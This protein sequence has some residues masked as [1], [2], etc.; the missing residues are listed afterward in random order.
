MNEAVGLLIEAA[1][2]NAGADEP[3]KTGAPLPANNGE[4]VVPAP[5]NSDGVG[6]EDPPN[7]AGIKR[8]FF[9]DC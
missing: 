2:P 9:N 5:A 4:A 3:P 7:R 6:V 8:F 1:P